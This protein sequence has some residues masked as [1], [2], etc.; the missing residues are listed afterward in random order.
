[1]INVDNV[2]A[3]ETVYLYLRE[4]DVGSSRGVEELATSTASLSVAVSISQSIVCIYY[5]FS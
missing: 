5:T 3:C 2:S 1:M 4:G